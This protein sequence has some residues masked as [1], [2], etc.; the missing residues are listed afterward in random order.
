[1]RQTVGSSMFSQVCLACEQALP[2]GYSREFTWQP[3]TRWREYE[4]REKISFSP[5]LVASPFARA[6]SRS[7]HQNW[8]TVKVLYGSTVS[9]SVQYSE[10][11]SVILVPSYESRERRKW[12][13]VRLSSLVSRAFFFRSSRVTRGIL[14]TWGSRFCLAA[15]TER[16]LG[17]APIF[18]LKEVTVYTVRRF[19][20]ITTAVTRPNVAVSF[21]VQFRF[22][23][24]CP[25]TLPQ[26]NINPKWEKC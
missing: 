25:P 12:Q 17:Q 7:V 5:P 23:G 19:K 16:S 8:R 9:G 14:V 6:F 1:M 22:L 11:P 3:Y 10:E 24:N 15:L 4:G 21:W 13:R 18:H 26:A 20:E 2:L